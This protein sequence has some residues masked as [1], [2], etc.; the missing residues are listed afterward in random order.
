MYKNKYARIG[1]IG[2]GNMGSCL[3][4]GLRQHGYPAD[5]ITVSDPHPGKCA[6]LAQQW[7]I[8]SL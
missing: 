8:N 2:A 5:K 7:E 4:G 3:I 1:I 6:Q